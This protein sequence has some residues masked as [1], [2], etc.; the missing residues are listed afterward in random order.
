MCRVAQTTCRRDGD[1]TT[2]GDACGPATSRATIAKRAIGAVVNAN[3]QM[4]NFGLMTFYQDG[5]FPYF[6][7][8][9]GSTGRPSE[10]R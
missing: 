1:C 4:L 5:Y 2:I 9:S 8:T 6:L 10:R 7:N 3:H